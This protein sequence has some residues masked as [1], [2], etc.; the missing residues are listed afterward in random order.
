MMSTKQQERDALAEIYDIIEMLGENSYVGAALDGCL[1][2]AISNIENDFCE[3]MKERCE[4]RDKKIRSLETENRLLKNEIINLKAK[5]MN[6][7]IIE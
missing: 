6:G 4:N 3:S 2:L 7:G 5:I 1:D